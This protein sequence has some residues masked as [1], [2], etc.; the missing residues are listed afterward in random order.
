MC[1]KARLEEEDIRTNE[2]GFSQKLRIDVVGMLIFYA[3]VFYL[4]TTSLM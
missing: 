3:V 4:F 1:Q 2:E